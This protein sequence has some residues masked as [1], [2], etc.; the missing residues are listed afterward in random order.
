MNPPSKEAQYLSSR[1]EA[2]VQGIRGSD[3]TGVWVM[4]G[5]LFYNDR[6]FWDRSTSASY[7]AGL[8]KDEVVILD[9]IAEVSGTRTYLLDCKHD[10][11]HT[12]GVIAKA[13]V[14][15]SRP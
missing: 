12:M 8:K 11:T 14:A 4:Q 10:H 9:L 3:P 13:R 15:L 1:A 5:W 2:V 6:K 7:L